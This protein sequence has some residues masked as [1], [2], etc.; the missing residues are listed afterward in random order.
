[1]KAVG[2]QRLAVS[3]RAQNLVGTSVQDMESGLSHYSTRDDLLVLRA[4]L[5]IVKRRKETTKAKILAR[6]IKKVEIGLGVKL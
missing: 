5:K 1:M 2:G 3:A 6:R 4:A